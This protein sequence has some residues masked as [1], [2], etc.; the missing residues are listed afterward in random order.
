MADNAL[1]LYHANCTDGFGAAWAFY[2]L[3]A[4]NY[5]KVHYIPVNY[6]EAPPQEAFTPDASNQDLFILDFSYPLAELV[7]LAKFNS[8]V[9]VLDHHISA[10]NTLEEAFHIPNITAIFD[11]NKSGAGLV[12]DYFA[13][14]GT[15]RPKLI[16]YIED[17]DLWR[18][19]QHLSREL[20]AVIGTCK[21]E[22][23]A[24]DILASQ[25]ENS[26]GTLA[27]A[28]EF[29]LKQEDKYVQSICS[30]ARKI[31]IADY[32]VPFVECPG[33]LASVVG[34]QLAGKANF[35]VTYHT[36][37]DG[38]LKFSLRAGA[39]CN[40]S[41]AA[42]AKDFFGGGGHDKAAGFVLRGEA[43][44]YLEDLHKPTAVLWSP[45]E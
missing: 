2:K 13:L 17:R 32:E 10:K 22:F 18:W 36:L 45:Q 7:Q 4:K 28:G 15:P 26:A 19:Q 6:S 12:W 40:I 35:S 41:M 14:D 20:N 39:N 9:V 21:H 43:L 3:A 24:F 8:E 23:K 29:L 16:D 1:V 30:L 31:K 11:N 44:D 34:N 37:Q 42:L 33:I 5:S 25:L 38:S 27:I